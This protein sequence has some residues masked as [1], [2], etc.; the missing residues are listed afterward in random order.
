MK[1]HIS[2][3]QP[4]SRLSR[5]MEYFRRVFTFNLMRLDVSLS[6]CRRLVILLTIDYDKTRQAALQSLE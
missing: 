6:K 3:W 1:A 2:I 5:L 4:V